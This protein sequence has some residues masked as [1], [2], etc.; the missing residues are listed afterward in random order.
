MRTTSL[1]EDG[2]LADRRP[3]PPDERRH[4]EA[5]FVNEDEAGLQ[6]RGVFFTRAQS[7]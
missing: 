4:E 6:L 1:V 7:S 5:A 3:G 2:G